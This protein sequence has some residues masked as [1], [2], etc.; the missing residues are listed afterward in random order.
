LIAD[1][2][3]RHGVRPNREREIHI[4]TLAA[5]N[6]AAGGLKREHTTQCGNESAY[7]QASVASAIE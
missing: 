4:F 2:H 6:V 7:E 5:E 3:H 1:D